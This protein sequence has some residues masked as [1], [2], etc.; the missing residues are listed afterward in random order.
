[1]YFT[2]FVVYTGVEQ[3]AFGSGSL[4]GVDVRTDTDITVAGNGCFTSHLIPLILGRSR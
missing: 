3:N 2:D 1:M 4:T